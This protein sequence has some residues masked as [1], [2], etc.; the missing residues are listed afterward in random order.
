MAGFVYDTEPICRAVVTARIL[1]AQVDILSVF[2]A[3]Q[4]T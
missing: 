4:H 1:R 3:F 2:R